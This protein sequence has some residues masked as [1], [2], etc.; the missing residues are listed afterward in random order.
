MKK[1]LLVLLFAISAP[2][3]A[4]KFVI[5]RGWG[6]DMATNAPNSSTWYFKGIRDFN[7]N[8]AMDTSLQMT[9]LDGAAPSNKISSRIDIGAIAKMNLYGP[10]NGYTR[11]AYGE[12][13]STSSPGNFDYYSVEPGVRGTLYGPVWSQVGWRFRTPFNPANNDTTRTWRTSLNYDVTKQDT[14]GVRLDN[15]RGDSNQNIFNLN[16][17]RSF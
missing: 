1:L 5:E 3:F 12:K 15:Q 17:V 10:V 6:D 11:V 14:V 2:A 9:Q 4:D 13:F 8:F 16:Y 7:P